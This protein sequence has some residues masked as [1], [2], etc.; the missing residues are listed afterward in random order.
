MNHPRVHVNVL[1]I[2]SHHPSP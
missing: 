2:S 1:N